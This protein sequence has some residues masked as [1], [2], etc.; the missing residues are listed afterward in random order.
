MYFKEFY[1]ELEKI[2]NEIY[3]NKLIYESVHPIDIIN[4]N[5]NV[6]TEAA[7]AKDANVKLKK[8]I[9]EKMM[10]GVMKFLKMGA[11]LVK[12]NSSIIDGYKKID[13]SLI[14]FNGFEAE[15]PDINTAMNNINSFKVP[16]FKTEDIELLLNNNSIG[17]KVGSTSKFQ[18]GIFNDD[19]QI[20]KSYFNG[21]VNNESGT[22][23]V[24][25]S[26][27][28]NM[29]KACLT[30]MD[31]RMD[32]SNRIASQVKNMKVFS[33]GIM[34]NATRGENNVTTESVLLDYSIFKDEYFD[35]LLEDAATTPNDI[36]KEEKEANN[37]IE[38]NSENSK[39]VKNDD[40]LIDAVI[41]YNE[42]I[43]A[44]ET[45]IMT[46]LDQLYTEASKYCA[47]VAQL[48]NKNNK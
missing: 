11:E 42:I 39:N 12:R 25:E 34:R 14:D 2:N 18:Q 41:R 27:A 23:K 48:S 20:N 10:A 46:S 43:Y 45:I 1:S 35:I 47:K 40:K 8:N 4:G 3:K 16:E 17:Y 22:I 36:Q 37:G 15:I 33:E 13:T 30:I 31:K 26:S 32:M 6:L 29:F 21:K 38:T 5:I 28:P 7:E 44:I 19:G 9:L 24:N